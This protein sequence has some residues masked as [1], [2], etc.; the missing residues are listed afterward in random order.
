[1]AHKRCKSLV[2]AELLRKETN[3]HFIN[4]Q[5]NKID[6]KLLAKHLKEKDENANL[7]LEI[8]FL[9]DS[10]YSDNQFITYFRSQS[11]ANA[12]SIVILTKT[13]KL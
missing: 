3:T 9:D 1:M 8:D 13:K 11:D 4:P 12:E 6:L 7:E 5:T 2:T 10:S